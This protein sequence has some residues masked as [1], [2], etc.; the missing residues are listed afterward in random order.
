MR[1][2]QPQG[3]T[4]MLVALMKVNWLAVVACVIILFLVGFVWFTVFARQWAELTGWT[5][6]KVMAQPRSKLMMSYGLT[7]VTAFVMASAL[8]II[9]Q[10]LP[11]PGFRGA[12]AAA[13][14]VWVGFTAAPAA[15]N[16]AFEQRPWKLYLLVNVNHLVGL[17]LSA[18]VLTVWK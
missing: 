15:S 16:T 1:S 18:V 11:T 9:L 10:L 17:L 5:R 4:H 3:E 7:L 6:E 8:A 14:L 12:L 2:F 13:V